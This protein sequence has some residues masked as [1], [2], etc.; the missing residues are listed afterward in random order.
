MKIDKITKNKNK[1]ILKLDNGDEIKTYDEVILN[2]NLLFNKEIDDNLL[3]KILDESNYYEMYYKVI[4]YIST[5]MRSTYE[6][7]K[8]LEKQ[9]FNN[10]KKLINELKEKKLL[11]DLLFVK[12]FIQDKINLTNNGPYKIKKEL[13]DH[14]ISESIIDDELSVFNEELVTEKLNKI[15]AKQLKINRTKSKYMLKQKLV[16]NL[17]NLGYSKETIL[18]CIDNYEINDSDVLKKEYDILYKKLSK[19]YSENELEAKIKN[20]LYQ[21]GF[22]ISDI[23]NILE[24]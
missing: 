10:N 7:E 21:K 14:N 16:N 8:Y 11:N 24:K 2:N 6:I 12:A 4:K 20:K 13:L 3:N 19:K 18:T 17:I 9:Q 23:N 22:D 5:K 1:Y 15:I